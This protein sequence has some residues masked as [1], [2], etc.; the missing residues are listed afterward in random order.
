MRSAIKTRQSFSGRKMTDH[1]LDILQGIHEG[2]AALLDLVSSSSS[3][4]QVAYRRRTLV[5]SGLGGGGLEEGR[6]NADGG[7][8]KVGQEFTRDAR[9]DGEA[10]EPMCA[11]LAENQDFN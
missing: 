11:T 3:A 7:R 2:V 5:Q 4:L 6:Q 1:E 9:G 8:E 10:S